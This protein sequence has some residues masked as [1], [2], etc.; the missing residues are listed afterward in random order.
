MLSFR[1]EDT[2]NAPIF[3]YFHSKVLILF[4]LLLCIRGGGPL[5]VEEYFFFLLAF[6]GRHIGLPLHCGWLL[7]AVGAHRRAPFVC[8]FCLLNSSSALEEGD[9]LRWRSISSSCLRIRADTLLCPYIAVVVVCRR[10]A[11]ACAPICLRF[12]VFLFFCLQAFSSVFSY[13]NIKNGD[14]M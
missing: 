14:S 10:G 4:K 9:R 1:C 8:V 2:K 12:F 13:P 11:P 3:N 7:F 6:S 5:A